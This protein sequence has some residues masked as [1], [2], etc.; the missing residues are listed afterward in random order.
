LSRTTCPAAVLFPRA[1]VHALVHHRPPPPPVGCRKALTSS[2]LGEAVIGSGFEDD[3][4]QATFTVGL[5]GVHGAANADKLVSAVQG[6]CLW[7]AT[8]GTAHLLA[9]VC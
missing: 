4:V 6:P 5:R 9:C 2:G 1:P 7:P 3:L 8:S